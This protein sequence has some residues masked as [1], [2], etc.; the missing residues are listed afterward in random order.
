MNK[1]IHW[2]KCGQWSPIFKTEGTRLYLECRNC[3]Q[4]TT[5][6]ITGPETSIGVRLA[7]EIPRKDMSRLWR[8]Y[9]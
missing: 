6:I 5:G 8:I 7:E 2:L 3:G 9:Y 1:L 4:Q